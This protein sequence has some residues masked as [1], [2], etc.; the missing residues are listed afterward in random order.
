MGDREGTGQ[1]WEN[2][3]PFGTRWRIAAWILA[4]ALIVALI[5]GVA[6]SRHA[7]AP[8]RAGEE[9]LAAL[10]AGDAEALRAQGLWTETDSST[11]LLEHEGA[12][13][14]TGLLEEVQVAGGEWYGEARDLE[15]TATQD[16]QV[17][18]G[19]VRAEPIAQPEPDGPRWRLPSVQPGVLVLDLPEEVGAVRVN[20]AEI[21][22]E[23][24]RTLGS[25]LP[26][27]LLAIPGDYTVEALPTSEH[28]VAAPQEARVLAV[29]G[30]HDRTVARV[31]PELA[32]TPEAV[33]AV[34]ADALAAQELCAAER[35]RFTGCGTVLRDL[36]PG[37]GTGTV[38]WE[39]HEDPEIE[40]RYLQSGTGAVDTAGFADGGGPTA[41]VTFAPADGGEAR[42][43]EVRYGVVGTVSLEDDGTLRTEATL[44]G[45]PVAP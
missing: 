15:I 34:R 10:A 32:F 13:P 24:L 12:A 5:T 26:R 29:V 8:Q 16:G 1:R 31:S 17:L 39:F 23:E 14:T 19:T 4:A 28:L 30:D 22:A 9:Y 33:E 27:E 45:E 35:D 40:V 20:G 42:T 3:G 44:V 2:P 41:T 21:P 6:V 38:L 11:L 7:A 37:L 25:G 43:L 36:G 18:E